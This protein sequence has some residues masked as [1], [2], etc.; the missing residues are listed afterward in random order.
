MGAESVSGPLADFVYTVMKLL[1]RCLYGAAA[2]NLAHSP[3]GQ[4]S[5]L[6]DNR[7]GESF[8]VRGPDC[9]RQ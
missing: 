6:R 8:A 7:L 4:S 9:A 1:G 2:N 3:R 5:G